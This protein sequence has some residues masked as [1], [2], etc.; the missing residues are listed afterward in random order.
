MGLDII[1][2]F[3]QNMEFPF[4][5]QSSCFLTIIANVHCYSGELLSLLPAKLRA[6]ILLH[7]PAIDLYRLGHCRGL[8]EGLPYTCEDVWK[9]RFDTTL[10]KYS[11]VQPF[12]ETKDLLWQERYFLSCLINIPKSSSIQPPFGSSFFVTSDIVLCET[13]QGVLKI[14][15]G[16]TLHCFNALETKVKTKLTSHFLSQFYTN[17]LKGHPFNLPVGSEKMSLYNRLK[18]ILTLFPGWKPSVI[19]LEY[20]ESITKSIEQID[21]QL[22]ESFISNANSIFLSSRYL[23]LH[24]YAEIA[25]EGPDRP[26]PSANGL[27]IDPFC[28]FMLDLL[29]KKSVDPPCWRVYLSQIPVIKE[30]KHQ[31]V[32]DEVESVSTFVQLYSSADVLNWFHHRC[33]NISDIIVSMHNSNQIDCQNCFIFRSDALHSVQLKVVRPTFKRF[34]SVK[35]HLPFSRLASI[36]LNGLAVSGEEFCDILLLILNSPQK[37]NLKF[38]NFFVNQSSD[39]P[40]ELPPQVMEMDCRYKTSLS[41]H[42]VNGIYHVQNVLETFPEVWLDDLS[43]YL[44]DGIVPLPESTIINC[45]SVHADRFSADEH[46]LHLLS[47]VFK[48]AEK[49]FLSIGQCGITTAPVAIA[50]LCQCIRMCETNLAY[51]DCKHMMSYIGFEASHVIDFF[52]AVLSLPDYIFES[53]VFNPSRLCESYASAVA[54]SQSGRNFIVNVHHMRQQF[55]S[56]E[57]ELRC[58]CWQW[59]WNTWKTNK[60]GVKLNKLVGVHRDALEQFEDEIK[61]MCSE[62]EL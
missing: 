26:N 16:S 35:A 33:P 15:Y 44:A 36:T 14:K 51:L 3:C 2:L 28:D 29:I 42:R 34:I 41:L 46:N 48:K 10:S 18:C 4:S 59:L 30:T 25:G 1:N 27:A 7:I 45:K 60:P 20:D 47:H 38:S 39:M 62:L 13:M 40:V 17:K 61:E 8:W 54:S 6:R 19:P 37:Q 43:F 32:N 9:R 22:C 52:E 12:Q 57:N 53:L 55:L 49:V 11:N 24:S 50:R 5:L 31:V 58:E 56:K 21:E 23:R